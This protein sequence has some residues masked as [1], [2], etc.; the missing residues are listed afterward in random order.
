VQDKEMYRTFNM[1]IGMVLVTT[2]E[3]SLRVISHLSKHKEHAWVIGEI[4]K[5]KGVS[6]Q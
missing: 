3:R 4:M 2:K 5:G 6:I 1:G